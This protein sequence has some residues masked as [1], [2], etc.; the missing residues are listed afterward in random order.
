MS[1]AD[2]KFPDLTVQ[3]IDADGNVFSII[4]SVA[5]A[6]RRSHGANAAS[7]FT[8]EAFDCSSYSEVLSL[9]MRTVNVT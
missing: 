9:T 8:N 5:G 3:L 1:D 2:V 4:S 7:E 6:I